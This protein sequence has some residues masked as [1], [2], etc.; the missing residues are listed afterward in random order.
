MIRKK[1]TSILKKENKKVE[2]YVAI[3][4]QSNNKERKKKK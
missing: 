4:E 3:M 2:I 1:E